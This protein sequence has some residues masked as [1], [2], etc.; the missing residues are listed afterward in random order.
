M[1][2]SWKGTHDRRVIVHC[3]YR[4]LILTQKD[5]HLPQGALFQINNQLKQCMIKASDGD[6]R[7]Q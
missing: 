7:Q 4:L 3:L 6:C 1:G 2:E 5:E